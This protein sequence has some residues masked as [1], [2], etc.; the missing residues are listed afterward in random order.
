MHCCN[1]HCGE[2][3][4]RHGGLDDVTAVPSCLFKDIK[5]II[6]QNGSF[7]CFFYCLLTL[8]I[9]PVRIDESKNCRFFDLLLQKGEKGFKKFQ[10]FFSLQAGDTFFT[11]AVCFFVKVWRIKDDEISFFF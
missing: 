2:T 3:L 10:V 6:Y 5:I 11:I 8:K 4:G 9:P 7:A 1:D